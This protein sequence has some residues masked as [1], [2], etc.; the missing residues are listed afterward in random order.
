MLKVIF[1]EDRTPQY[2][3]PFSLSRNYSTFMKQRGSLPC[4]HSSVIRSQTESAGVHIIQCFSKIHFNIILPARIRSSFQ[5][6]SS[7]QVSD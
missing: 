1:L 3:I 2:E 5:V 4:P 6:I 7:L